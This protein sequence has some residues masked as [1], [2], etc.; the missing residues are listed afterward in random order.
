M[1]NQD[2][3]WEMNKAHH[4]KLLAV[5]N[6]RHLAAHARRRSVSAQGWLSFIGR[7]RAPRVAEGLWDLSLARP[8]TSR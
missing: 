2:A 4:Q 6:E 7:R 1:Y 3:M 5:A 8:D